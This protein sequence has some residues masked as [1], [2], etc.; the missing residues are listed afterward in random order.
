MPEIS[1]D[2]W[3]VRAVLARVVV[4]GRIYLMVDWEGY[5]YFFLYN[6]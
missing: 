3:P 1:A 5:S 2:N 6:F 4:D